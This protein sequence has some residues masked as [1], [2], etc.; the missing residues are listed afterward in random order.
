[1]PASSPTVAIRSYPCFSTRLRDLRANADFGADA[2]SGLRTKRIFKLFAKARA[3][4]VLLLNP[5]LVFLVG[6][7]LGPGAQLSIASTME[8]HGG[9]MAQ[10][11]HQD[12]A[13]FRDR[14]HPL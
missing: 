5:D 3:L 6:S 10:P 9:E 7:R 1:M 4:D 2:F 8:I 14:P 12:D 13:Y 11:L